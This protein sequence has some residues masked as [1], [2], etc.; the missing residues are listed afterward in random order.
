MQSYGDFLN[1]VWRRH[2]GNADVKLDGRRDWSLDEILAEM[3]D[4]AAEARLGKAHVKADQLLRDL[5]ACLATHVPHVEDR[6]RVLAAVEA[7]EASAH[8]WRYA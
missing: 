5:V 8:T 7:H 3:Q 2:L 6:A 1:A 4:I